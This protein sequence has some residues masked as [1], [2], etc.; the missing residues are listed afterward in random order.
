MAVTI[1]KGN[2]LSGVKN[3]A[4]VAAHIELLK[5]PSLT[6]R[7][8]TDACGWLRGCCTVLRANPKTQNAAAYIQT[9]LRTAQHHDIG[10]TD[11]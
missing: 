4:Q 3:K 1:L 9:V 8:F 5:D 7:E 10:D 6:Y 2:R 11:E